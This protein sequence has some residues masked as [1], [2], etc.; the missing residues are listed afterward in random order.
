MA[1]LCATLFNIGH[2]HY[3]NE[4]IPQAMKAWVEVY[5]RAK[6]MNLAQALDALGNLAE[7]LG[8]AGGLEGWEKVAKQIEKM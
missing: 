4:E 6:S 2:I 7:Q 3:Q 5:R 8:L 1:G